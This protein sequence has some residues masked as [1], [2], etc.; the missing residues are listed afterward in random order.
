MLAG[1]DRR[2]AAGALVP[3]F[4]I[5]SSGLA[6]HSYIRIDRNVIV[7]FEATVV[8]FDW[9]NPHVAERYT[10]NWDYTPDFEFYRYDR[11]P[12]V[13]ARLSLP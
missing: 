1:V 2:A 6:H 10:L 8:D 5:G 12:E 11:D 3:C 13:A 7:A 4:A 9:R